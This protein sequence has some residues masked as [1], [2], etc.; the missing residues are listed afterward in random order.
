MIIKTG[1]HKC[2]QETATTSNEIKCM[3]NRCIERAKSEST[4][5][6]TI[7]TEVLEEM[8]DAGMDIMSQN[9]PKF[10]SIKKTIYRHRKKALQEDYSP[11]T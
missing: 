2:S 6:S 7:Y 8:K 4:P 11:L 5:V 3:I 10:S 1:Q 9:L